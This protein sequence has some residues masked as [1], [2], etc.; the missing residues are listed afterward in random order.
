M[1]AEAT[2]N[3]SSM[4]NIPSLREQVYTY[5]RNSMNSGRLKPGSMFNTSRL[6]KE[7]GIS[8][9]PLKEALIKL[10]LQG[11]VTIVPRRGMIVN[12]LTKNDIKNMYEILG[13]L[14][15]NALLSVFDQLGERHIKRM[16]LSNL[17]QEQA[18]EAGDYN[19]YYRLN[20][21]FHDIFLDLSTNGMFKKL[22]YPLKQ[23]LYD[24]P[25]RNYLKEWEEINLE[26]H[27]QFIACVEKNDPHGAKDIWQ[28]EHWGWN[29][30][31]AYFDKFY[32]LKE[33]EVTTAC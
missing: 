32:S 17:E 20:I 10:E 6:S 16:K 31:K 8:K 2:E 28:N 19:R 33:N 3:G 29:K 13:L 21:D 5:L 24:F 14:E 9:T 18:I 11:F 12:Q 7:L 4:L 15:A 27:R 25:R 30:H 23:R 22:A 26:E 1:I